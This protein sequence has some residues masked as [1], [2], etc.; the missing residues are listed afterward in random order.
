[1]IINTSFY[2]FSAWMDGWR[3]GEKEDKKK[4]EKNRLVPIA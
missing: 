2:I 3:R 1:M 4:K